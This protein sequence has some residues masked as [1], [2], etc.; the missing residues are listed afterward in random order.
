MLRRLLSHPLTRGLDIDHPGTTALRRWIIREKSLLH[1]VYRRWYAQI[2]EWVPDSP[3]PALELGSGPGF[4]DQ[5]VPRLITSEIFHCPGVRAQLDAHRLCFADATLRAV[6]MV[7]VLHHLPRPRRFFAE[8][9]RCVEIGGTLVMIEPWV[10][11]WST[12]I[13]AGLHHE[14]FCPDS[15]EWDFPSSGPLS[16]ANG[17]LPWIIFQR[18]RERFEREFPGWRIETIRPMMPLMYLWSGGV[19]L[20]AVVPGWAWRPLDAVDRMLGPSRGMFALIVLRRVE[21]P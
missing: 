13:Y 16:G 12:R 21:L 11:R 10:N 4:L 7:D 6:A 20:R 14:P 8:A 5:F 9:M 3:A 18:D 17:A 19:S 2:A 1:R 15:P